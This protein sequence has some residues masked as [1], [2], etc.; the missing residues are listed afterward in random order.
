MTRVDSLLRWLRSPAATWSTAGAFLL[1]TLASGLLL[2]LGPYGQMAQQLAEL[3]LTPLEERL[4]YSPAEFHFLLE[5]LGVEGR[6]LFRQALR[7]DLLYP[8]AFVPALALGI[9]VPFSRVLKN[10]RLALGLTLLPLLCA[11]CDWLEDG[12]LL[13]LLSAFPHED[14][15]LV[16]LASIVT[17]TKLLLVRASFFLVLLGLLLA[18]GRGLLQRARQAPASR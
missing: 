1:F 2:G 10:G 7:F 4:G 5:K 3:Q 16:G 9:A 12:L 13:S 18:S 8:L 17:A 14:A 15:R 11:P 6:G